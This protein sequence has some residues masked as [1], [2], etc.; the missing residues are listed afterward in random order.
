MNLPIYYHDSS[1]RHE[2]GLHPESPARV[3]ATVEHLRGLGLGLD[4]RSPAP[5]SVDSLVHLFSAMVRKVFVSAGM[6]VLLVPGWVTLKSKRIKMDII[7]FITI[8]QNGT[9][10]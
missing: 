1:L 10:K 9:V 4:W 3:A 5:A 2:T 8:D 7:S 6:M